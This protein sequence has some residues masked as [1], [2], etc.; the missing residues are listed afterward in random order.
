MNYL[1]IDDAFVEYHRNSC[2]CVI[3]RFLATFCTILYK[4]T[5]L[6]TICSHRPTK[7]K[8]TSNEI[9]LLPYQYHTRMKN[10]MDSSKIFEILKFKFYGFECCFGVLQLQPIGS[11]HSLQYAI[12]IW[13]H[14]ISYVVIEVFTLISLHIVA[15]HA[16]V[17]R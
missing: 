2:V 5:F 13:Q 6:Q 15:L 16:L 17:K 10:G 12:A 1:V 14:R 3:T 11:L 9:F 7:N 4:V 8:N